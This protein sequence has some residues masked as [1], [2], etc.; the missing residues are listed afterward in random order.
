MKRVFF[1]AF[2]LFLLAAAA[3]TIPD[4][5]RYLKMRAM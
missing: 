1:S 4:I 3:S 2:G 5:R